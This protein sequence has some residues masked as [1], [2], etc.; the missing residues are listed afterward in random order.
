MSENI[1]F[2]THNVTD[3]F[4]AVHPTEDII[5]LIYQDENRIEIYSKNLELIKTLIGPNDF[6]PEYEIREGDGIQVSYKV[7]TRTYWLCFHN[8]NHIYVIY[9]G[10]CDGLQNQPVNL[11]KFTWDGTPI[12]RFELDRNLYTIYVDPDE[13]Y[14]YGTEVK[15]GD[16][17]K[18]IRYN[19][20]L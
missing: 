6:K 2:F 4:I 14:A 11:L 15:Q 20:G 9:Y 18:L 7:S 13:E 10:E 16:S 1:K 12:Q 5:W 17:P 19:I 3:G 8:T